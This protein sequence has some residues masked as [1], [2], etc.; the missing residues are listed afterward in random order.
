MVHVL[1]H[2]G[3]T[4]L[5]VY[6]YRISPQTFWATVVA[7]AQLDVSSRA[8]HALSDV[9]SSVVCEALINHEVLFILLF[10]PSEREKVL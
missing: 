5:H 2:G 7:C 1:Y 3:I 10:R 8:P 6:P 4:R 9:R